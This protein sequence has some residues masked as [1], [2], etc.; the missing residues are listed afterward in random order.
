MLKPLK[1]KDNQPVYWHCDCGKTRVNGK[2]RIKVL[3]TRHGE[4]E[5]NIAGVVNGDPKKPF[6]LTAK[7]KKQ[8][9]HLAKK[10]KN[11][12]FVAIIS[13]EMPRTRQTAQEISKLTN[14]EVQVDKR[15]NDI[16]AGKLEG[17]PILEF[18]K[19]TN[20]VKKSVK[21]SETNKDLGKRLKSFLEDLLDCYSGQTVVIVSSEI[22]LHALLQVSQGKPCDE[23]VGEHLHHGVTYEFIIN[24]PVCCPSCGDSCP[25]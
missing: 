20:N 9:Q 10:L 11:K 14:I 24:S 8:V 13:S 6:H 5:H 16:K 12:K 2:Q 18:R 4:S 25:I 17:I 22:I 1:N 23:D 19:I 21:G 3:A 15:L 7:G